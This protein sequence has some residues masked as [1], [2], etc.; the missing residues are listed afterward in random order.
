MQFNFGLVYQTPSK[1]LE[2]I[3]AIIQEIIEKHE[4][5]TFDRAHFKEYGDFALIFEVVYYVERSEYDHYMDIQQ[6][7]NLDIYRRF[8]EKN[9]EM[10]YPTQTI[11][12]EK[13]V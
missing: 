6:S 8:E 5:V 11:H 7:I 9:I 4:N 10:A 2:I 12:L 3:P 13:S 1:I